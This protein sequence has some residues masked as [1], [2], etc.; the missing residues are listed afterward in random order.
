[1]NRK[2]IKRGI[3]I[4]LLASTILCSTV[5]AEG[6]E[7]S[8]SSTYQIPETG[9]VVE[10]IYINPIMAN[11]EMKMMEA[12]IEKNLE[13]QEAFFEEVA[14]AKV[15][16]GSF[17]YIRKNAKNSSSWVGKIYADDLATIDKEKGNWVKVSSGDVVGYV[18][19]SSLVTGNKAIK[20]AKKIAM[21]K[22]DAVSIGV[23]DIETVKDS[24][25]VAV[26][27]KQVNKESKKKGKEVV[28]FANKFIGNPYVY[29][30]TS[31]TKGADCSG[32]VK[33]VYEN[34]GVSLPHSSYA[35]RQVGYSVSYDDIREGDIV[36]YQGH[37]GIYAGKGRIVNA[38]DERNGIKFSSVNYSKIICIRRIF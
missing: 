14:F 31:L 9:T 15:E 19:K 36:C 3:I 5:Q 4:T 20:K 17:L 22:N 35:M 23:L 24:Y 29:G 6:L 7:K 37:V 27:K 10:T 8:N 34:F 32:F 1:M 2:S 16:K 26:S 21:E 25:S 38:V 28:A 11:I 13:E 18:K 30:G 33:A 12:R